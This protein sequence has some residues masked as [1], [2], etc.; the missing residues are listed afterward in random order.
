MAD[1]EKALTALHQVGL[2]GWYVVGDR[3]YL[4]IIDF[5]GHQPG[6]KDRGNSKIPAMPQNAVGC[7]EMPSEL[8]RTE[9]N[10]TEGA[11]KSAAPLAA[12][13]SPDPLAPDCKLDALVLKWND[14]VTAP[15]P[16]CRGLSEQ[17]K[18]HARARLKEN[19][20]DDLMRG[21]DAIEASDFCHGKNDRQWVP[22]F[23]WYV[24]SQENV[25][26]V[27][28][29]KYRNRGAPSPSGSG[30]PGVPD[31]DATRRLLAHGTTDSR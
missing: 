5:H 25:N 26:K 2:V 22:D 6:L 29:G 30:V 19:R 1:F 14:T 13:G 8:N 20:L 24:G 4:Q 31:V 11:A 9:Q 3:K 23:G 16:K 15:I 28:E 7:R 10:R 27:L 18:G 12:V 17:R 21:I